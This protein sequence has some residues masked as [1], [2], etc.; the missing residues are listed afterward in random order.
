[1]DLTQY[2]HEIAFVWSAGS[3][4]SHKM[5]LANATLAFH[6]SNALRATHQ[7][8][9]RRYRV[10]LIGRP[11]DLWIRTVGGDFFVLHEVFGSGCYELPFSSS[12]LRTVVD[13]GANIGLTT[14]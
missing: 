11:H 12:K 13:L 4:L 3:G 6:L 7:S 1:M 14:L 2:A 5:R 8:L 9:P 10:N